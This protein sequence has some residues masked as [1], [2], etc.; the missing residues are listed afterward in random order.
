MAFLPIIEPLLPSH[1]A[2]EKSALPALAQELERKAAKL[3]GH[4]RPNVKRVL[5]THMRVMNSYYSNKIEGNS[6]HP[7]EIRRAMSGDYSTDPAQR[8]LQQE[9]LAHIAVQE[10]LDDGG[11]AG[12]D[13]FSSKA[14]LEI[15]RHFY[16]Q[17]P[18]TLRQVR[19]ADPESQAVV[20][21]GQFRDRM[22]DVGLHVPPSPTEIQAYLARLQASY[23]FGTLTGVRRIIGIIC[24]HHRLLWVHPF[25]DGNGRVTR[26]H[27]DLLLKEAGVGATGVWCLSRGLARN[28]VAYKAALAKADFG[29]MGDHDGRGNL[30]EKQL[31]AFCEFMMKTAIDQVDYITGVLE[32]GGMLKRIEAYFQRRN[33]GLIPGM[34][35]I[36][37]QA[38]KLVERAFLLGEFK[39]SECAEITGLGTSVTRKLVQ[40]LKEEGLLTETSSRSPLYWAIPEHAEGFYLPGLSPD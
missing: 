13:L 9:S 16:Q 26:L 15:H 35:S 40:Q 18:D 4:M 23:G 11:L 17:I 33:Q 6:T 29:R 3:E 5:T 14:L 32:L 28:S 1:S 7:R 25:L 12:F 10:W 19:G 30:S 2:T 31:I 21:P 8:D 39:R 38:S 24:C 27:T 36:K 34:R 20:I 37:P 22:V